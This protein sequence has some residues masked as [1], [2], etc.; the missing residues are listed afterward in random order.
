MGFDVVFREFESGVP[1]SGVSWGT[2]SPWFLVGNGGTK[3]DLK[4]TII[5]IHSFSRAPEFPS[6]L[7]MCYRIGLRDH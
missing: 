4:A 2:C 5:E 3:R 6:I 1:H 7:I